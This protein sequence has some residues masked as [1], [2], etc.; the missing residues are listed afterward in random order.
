VYYPTPSSIIKNVVYVAYNKYPCNVDGLTSGE[1]FGALLHIFV[2]KE[3]YICYGE[4]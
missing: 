2:A 1:D 4:L 3:T